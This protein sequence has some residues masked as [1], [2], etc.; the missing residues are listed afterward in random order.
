MVPW[1]LND[2]E[3]VWEQEGRRCGYSLPIEAHWSLRLPIIRNVRYRYISRAS[4]VVDALDYSI[5]CRPV[6]GN[7]HWALY[8]IKKGWV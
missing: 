4:D 3:R 2:A 6:V 7:R 5:G 8:A 1:V